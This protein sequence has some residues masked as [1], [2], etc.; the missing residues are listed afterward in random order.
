V[1]LSEN[2]LND[3]LQIIKQF[4]SSIRSNQNGL[5]SFGI[6]CRNIGIVTNGID[7][8]TITQIEPSLYKCDIIFIGR[9]IKEKNLDILIGSIDHLRKCLP[10]IKCHIIGSGPE[11]K[12]LVNMVIELKLKDHITFFGFLDYGEVIAMIKSSKVLVLP[13]IRE[14]FGIV[15]LEAFACGIPVVTVRSPQMQPVNW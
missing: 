8:K 6:N 9:F 3:C 2:S 5:L 1:V 12:R 11:E 14:G 13:S 4:D 15:V 10:D 7:I